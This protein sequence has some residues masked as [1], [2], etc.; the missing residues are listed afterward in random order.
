MTK[1]FCTKCARLAGVKAN[2]KGFQG[3]DFC[4]VRKAY[5]ENPHADKSM[6]APYLRFSSEP[7]QSYYDA[8][9]VAYDGDGGSFSGG[10]ADS[11]YDSGS[12]DSG[13][14]SD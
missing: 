5:E 6:L 2:R 1:V 14:S 3:C 10:G 4:I 13:G 8:R 9:S 11:S 7:D 12:C